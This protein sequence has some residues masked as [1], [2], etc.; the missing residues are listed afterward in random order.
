MNI[1]KLL[2]KVIS[3]FPS[4][5]LN[6]NEYYENEQCFVVIEDISTVPVVDGVSVDDE[7][8]IVIDKK[9]LDMDIYLAVLTYD[10]LETEKYWEKKND[11]WASIPANENFY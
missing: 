1:E 11:K 7:A 6:T 5:V 10:F 3:K 8:T 2:K 9:T 4:I